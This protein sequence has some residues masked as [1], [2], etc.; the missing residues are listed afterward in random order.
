MKKIIVYLLLST[1]VVL[2]CKVS[3]DTNV[4]LTQNSHNIYITLEPNANIENL[5]NELNKNYNIIDIN[6]INKSLEQYRIIVQAS[7]DELSELIQELD[8]NS[9]VTKVAKKSSNLGSPTNSS[10]VKTSKSSPLKGG[11]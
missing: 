3:Q 9:N 2:S 4:E 7:D 11:N 5:K 10:P 6:K 8:G 1:I